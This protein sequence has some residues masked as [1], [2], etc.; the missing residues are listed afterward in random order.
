GDTFHPW[1]AEQFNDN[2]GWNA[3]VTDLLTAEGTPRDNPATAFL[4]ANAENG[5][6]Q[7]NK[8]TGSTAALFL[9]VNLRCAECH[10]HPFA[11]WKQSDFWGMAAFFGK[12]QYS[13]S[14]G[15]GGSPG[16]AESSTVVSG[17]KEKGQPGAP[18]LR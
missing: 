5:R 18:M 17:G 8:V 15:K 7:P 10:R 6:P 16:L 14:G 12:V 13:G 11:N 4:L 2:R 9:G 3:I 1:L